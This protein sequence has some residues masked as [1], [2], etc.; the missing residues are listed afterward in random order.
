METKGKIKATVTIRQGE[1]ALA[2]SFNDLGN[3]MAIYTKDLALTAE[4]INQIL[5]RAVIWGLAVPWA[6]KY[7]PKWLR[8]YKRTKKGRTR[9]KYYNKIVREY[10]KEHPCL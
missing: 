4:R 6:E 5:A 7:R 10:R 2:G 8:I 3:A 9:K 1:G